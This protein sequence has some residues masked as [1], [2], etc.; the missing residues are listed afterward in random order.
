MGAAAGSQCHDTSLDQPDAANL[1][2]TN[3]WA[4]AAPIA[5]MADAR[6]R[7]DIVESEPDLVSDTITTLVRGHQPR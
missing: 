6:Q 5:L 2:T 7:G 3:D 1:R 4:F